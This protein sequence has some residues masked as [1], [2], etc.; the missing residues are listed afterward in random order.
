MIG[1]ITWKLLL[2]VLSA[3]SL[4]ACRGD[5][6]IIPSESESTGRPSGT[7]GMY[8]LNEGNMG[9]NK[10]TIDFYNFADGIYNRNIYAERN[11]QEVMELGDVGNDIAVYGS[12]LYITVN[13]SHKVEVLDASTAKKIK[14]IDVPNCRYLSFS[15]GNAYVSSYIGPVGADPHCPLGAVFRIDTVSLQITGE[16]A[17]GYQPEE[18]A[19]AGR[20]LFV[21]NSGGYRAPEF[22]STVSVISLD[23]FTP[24]YTIDAEINL[25][26]IK[27]D[28]HGNIWA[29]SRGNNLDIGS[30]ILKMADGGNG[31]YKV[32]ERFDI[33][34]TN[35]TLRGDSLLYMASENG[36]NTYGILDIRTGNK[37][38][39]FINASTAEKIM[40]PYALAVDPA[41]G[42]I[43]ITDARNYV[44]SGKIY[45]LS[46]DGTEKWSATTGDI[47]AAIAFMGGTASDFSPTLPDNDDES[48]Y[49]SRVFEYRPAPGQFVNLMPE[50]SDGDTETDMVRKCG[51]YICGTRESCISL[52]GFGGY[53][54]FG[55]DHP[56]RN[57]KGEMDFRIWGNAV[58]QSDD[59]RGGS[60]EPGIVMV[61]CDTNSNGIPDDEWYEL[62]GSEYYS[63]ATLHNYGITYTKNSDIIWTDTQGDRGVMARNQFH[64]QSYWPS[65]ISGNTLTF[66]GTRLAPNAEDKSG[67]G[68]NYILYSYPWGYA[69]NYPNSH[70]E[71]NSFD[72]GWAVDKEGK[73]VNLPFIH[74]IKVMTGIN[75]QCGRLGETSTEICKAKD[76]HY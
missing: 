62:A 1:K 44:S 35:F 36:K 66:S 30:S 21:A 5:E 75:Q 15:E 60:A 39:S 18:M 56:V 38:G 41:S 33:P 57:V 63:P 32:T 55:F 26:R 70:I 40:R 49:I 14:Q 29:N 24:A 16:V 8:V 25:H 46:A 23:T 28:R 67:D 7:G 47:P 53:V 4:C 9:S 54:T 11:P 71:G 42:D 45:C 43:F 51:E 65:W 34:C 22:D 61:S 6:V 37:L 72:I 68:T 17:T 69:D 20:Q 13:C 64:Q 19:I 10:C 31:K 76:L 50:Y 73:P 3:V 58:W 48:A 74:F 52:G 2:G 12:K 59:I 27:T